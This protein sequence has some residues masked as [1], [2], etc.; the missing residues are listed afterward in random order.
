MKVYQV[1]Q[2]TVRLDGQLVLHSVDF[3]LLAGEV[4]AITGV[5]GSGKTT[6][7]D[8]LF[9][10][11]L[12]DEG[13][14]IHR[15]ERVKSPLTGKV[16]YL[17]AEPE[18]YFFETTV[19]EEVMNVVGFTQEAGDAVKIAEEALLRAGLSKDYFKRDP[20]NLSR[21]EKRKVALAAVF[22]TGTSTFLLDEPFSGL[23]Y[24][25]IVDIATVISD[26]VNEGKSVVC[27]L[28]DPEPVFFLNPKLYLLESGKLHPVPLEKPAEAVELYLRNGLVPPERLLL[29]ARKEGVPVCT[30]EVEF[31]KQYAER[32]AEQ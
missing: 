20:L 18:R 10:F 27:T 2:V 7:L 11:L 12:P 5:S 13:E 26:L 16:A 30:G 28:H 4:A 1:N 15:G 21:G 14:V 24:A 29:A 19:I 23:D 6:L 17:I 9:G 25:S 22:A 31:I 8:T 32:L 3:E